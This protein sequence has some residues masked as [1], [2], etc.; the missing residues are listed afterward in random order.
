MH[1]RLCSV[2]LLGTLGI[3]T[4]WSVS[5]ADLVIFKD[6]YTLQGKIKRDSEYFVDPASNLQMNIPKLGGFFRVDDEARSIVL[7]PRQVPG[8]PA[9]ESN[10][11]RD[12]DSLRSPCRPR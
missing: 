7:S 2:F 12:L 5:Q 9:R 10:R 1:T 3:L 8:V 6:G 11:K 4:C